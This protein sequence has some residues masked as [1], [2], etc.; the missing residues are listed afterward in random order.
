MLVNQFRWYNFI[1]P[2]WP[3]FPLPLTGLLP[4]TFSLNVSTP[5]AVILG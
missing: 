4:R 1:P 3:T 5:M 2:Q